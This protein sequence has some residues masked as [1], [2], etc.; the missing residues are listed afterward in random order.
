MGVFCKFV[1]IN[2]I[3]NLI[4]VMIVKVIRMRTV[5]LQLYHDEFMFQES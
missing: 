2:D 5:T 1:T 4:G 3:S